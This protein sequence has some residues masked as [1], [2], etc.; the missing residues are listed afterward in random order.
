MYTPHSRS[1]GG[2]NAPFFV[3]LPNRH[4]TP[5]EE[6][7]E[8]SGR[9]FNW[10]R[11]FLNNRTIEVRVG[12]EFSSIYP[13]ENGTPQGSVCSPMLFNIMI[14]DIFNRIDQ[15]MGRALYADDGALWVRGRN[16]DN[17]K[18][19][20]QS[21]IDKVEKWSYEWGFHLSIEKTQFICFSKKRTNPTIDLKLCGQHLKQVDSIRYL[22]V[23][24]DVKLNFKTHI[25]KMIDKCKKG[26]NILKCLAGFSWGAS[27]MSLKRIYTALIR[28][29]LDYGSIVYSSTTKTLMQELDRVQAKALRICCGAFRTTPIPSLQ[30]EV[31]EM[32]LDLRR[33]KLSMSY[34]SNLQGHEETHPT[35]Q[36]LLECWEY[37]R[38]SCS[39]GWHGNRQ[40]KNMEID[41][42]A[43]CKTVSTPTIPPWMFCSPRVDLEVKNIIKSGKYQN[44]QQYIDIN[45]DDTVQIFTDASKDQ[46]GK[47][48]VAVHILKYNVN[49]KKRTTDH[50][51]IFTAE[52]LAIILALQ[53]V[54]EVK[55][56]K[57]IICSDSMS[58]LACIQ[59]GKSICRQDLL[60]E[61]NQF[62]FKSNQQSISVVFIWVPA[63]KG[64]EGNEKGDMLAKEAV[65]SEMVE[66]DIKL[67]RSEIK[68]IIK[69]KINRMW[70]E[71]WDKEVK[72]RHLYNIHK[73]VTASKI[74]GLE[75][76]EE[77]WFSRLRMG[78]TSL[79][80]GLHIIGK[81]QT[82]VCTNCGVIEN[83]KHILLD[84]TQY[85]RERENMKRAVKKDLT[86]ENLLSIK[87]TQSTVRA[88]IT[89]LKETQLASRI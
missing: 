74:S 81:H 28:S 80:S 55:P 41:S 43:C 56:N 48:G 6:E 27:V 71:R 58:S 18:V 33:L 79:N 52:M 53:W 57:V 39:F 89:F 46:T 49:I 2:G 87:S 61:I 25:Q 22:G 32:P 66:L 30:I 45:Y 14:N 62:I 4:K 35:K 15:R 9:M 19:K 60:D 17:L 73:E 24:F 29:V 67:S 86:M 44:V 63:H 16:I 77:T 3:G 47:T 75:R 83:V 23:W 65:T 11:D 38:P 88:V 10:I 64:V 70:Q 34:W 40:A 72:G 85:T 7:E 5:E 21:A 20:M 31:G 76:Q 50:L 8:L 26:I 82:G 42:I 84:C 37:G 51:A 69:D 78:H 12:M 59:S 1:V 54:E 68:S 36:V 13:I